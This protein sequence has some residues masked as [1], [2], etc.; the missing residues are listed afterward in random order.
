MAVAFSFP[1]P[2]WLKMLPNKIIYVLGSTRRA[3]LVLALCWVL[4]IEGDLTPE[5]E[6]FSVHRSELACI[7]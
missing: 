1:S 2:A 7:Q 5:W 6:Q 3:V 4:S